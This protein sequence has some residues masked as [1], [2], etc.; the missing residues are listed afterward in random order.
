M[1][2]A[3]QNNKQETGLVERI[4]RND[5]EAFKE[6]YLIYYE[7]LFRYAWN[8]TRSEERSAEFVQELFVRVWF[9]R[10]RLD[11]AQSIT[12]YL[13]RALKNL[14][15]DASKLSSSKNLHLEDSRVSSAG[16]DIDLKIDL[17]NAVNSLPSKLREV[18]LLSRR[19]GFK[20]S[21]I[22]TI[23]E[24]SV[25]AVEKRMAKALVILR[26]TFHGKYFRGEVRRKD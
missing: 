8:R 11:P 21:E 25:K 24:I 4:K 10:N 7:R 6:L 20:Y 22:S 16:K 12:A 23:C 19:D 13:F 26:K 3:D 1:L 9:N 5:K 15:I 18:Y 14:M 2:N 17:D